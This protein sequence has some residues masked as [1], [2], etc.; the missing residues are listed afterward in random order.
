MPWTGCKQGCREATGSRAAYPLPALPLEV[1]QIDS[2]VQTRAIPTPCLPSLMEL[3]LG[4]SCSVWD[5]HAQPSFLGT[6]AVTVPCGGCHQPG[7]TRQSL[8]TCSSACLNDELSLMSV[9]QLTLPCRLIRLHTLGKAAARGLLQSPRRAQGC[10]GSSLCVCLRVPTAALGP[11]HTHACARTR[12]RCC[13]RIPA[14]P[15]A[16]PLSP[17]TT[18]TKATQSSAGKSAWGRCLWLHPGRARPEPRSWRWAPCGGRCPEPGTCG[19]SG[20]ASHLGPARGLLAPGRE[21]SR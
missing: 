1:W 2:S 14:A 13:P 8:G 4:E 9:P 12:T 10:T 6:Q 5:A 11:A 19:H 7:G 15:T 21:G 17:L 18:A 20:H 3:A 16:P